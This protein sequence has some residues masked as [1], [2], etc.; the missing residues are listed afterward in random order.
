MQ[1]ASPEPPAAAAGAPG[2]DRVALPCDGGDAGSPSDLEQYE[3]AA[4]ALTRQAGALLLEALRS[5]PEVEFKDAQRRDPVTA[6]DRLI[7]DFLVD[8]LHSRF[9]G[10]GL[11]GE[12]RADEASASDYLWVMDPLDGTANFANGLPFCAVS[13]ALLHRGQPVVGCIFVTIGPGGQPGVLHARLGGGARFEEVPIHVAAPESP[14]PRLA[15]LPGGWRARFRLHGPAGR[16]AGDLRNLGSTCHE[17][18]LVACGALRW[19][20]FLSPKLW[21]VAAAVLLVQEAGGLA[22]FWERGGWRDAERFA[23]PYGSRDG[24]PLTLRDWSRPTLLGDPDSVELVCGHLAWRR[25]PRLLQALRRGWNSLRKRLA[26]Q[27]R[28]PA[29]TP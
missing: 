16:K 12:E 15:A 10:H 2:G 23:P 22:R 1:P 4:L 20:I 19:A 24:K 18:G 3:Q 14:A 26:L 17:G 27:P 5:P 28:Q 7:E 21:D 6:T 13:L 11:L 25:L 9:P 8:A 29:S